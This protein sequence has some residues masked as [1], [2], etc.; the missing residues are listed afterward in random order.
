[1]NSFATIG[2]A[3]SIIAAPLPALAEQEPQSID[4]SIVRGVNSFGAPA[5]DLPMG[6]LSNNYF[7]LGGPLALAVAADHTQFKVPVTTFVA[8]GLAGASV[9]ILKPLFGRPRPF[10]ADPSL[11]TPSGHWTEDPNSFPSGHAA[12]SFAAATAIADARPDYAWPAYGLAAL[13]SYSRMYNGVHYPSD[14]LAG[15]LLG[16][17]VGKATA[18]GMNQVTDRF[19]WP[20]SGAIAA[21][22]DALT[23][24]FGRQF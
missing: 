15:A 10:A 24:G 21:G 18:W 19:G 23:L 3:A 7:L 16:Y 20:I 2:L 5:L 12:I 8:E 4:L 6:A 22:G 17:G 14:L 11:R 9:M 13:I 1:M